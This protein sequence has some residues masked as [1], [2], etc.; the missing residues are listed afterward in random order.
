MISPLISE[1]NDRVELSGGKREARR[2]VARDTRHAVNENVDHFQALCDDHDLW[3]RAG[4]CGHCTGALA[5]IQ[6]RFRGLIGA[7]RSALA[8]VNAS[9]ERNELAEDELVNNTTIMVLRA[10]EGF[11]AHR[12]PE[13]A[14]AT[15]LGRPRVDIFAPP[16]TRVD[17][18]NPALGDVQPPAGSSNVNDGYGD[19]GV[20]DATGVVRP[21]PL[22]RPDLVK[23]PTDSIQISDM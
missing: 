19:P 20:E 1:L 11:F 13:V 7:Q 6:L 22:V 2:Q 10:V 16:K 8:A 23:D 17:M 18:F 5:E 15:P 12:P 4:Q 21:R 3:A 9:A 14:A